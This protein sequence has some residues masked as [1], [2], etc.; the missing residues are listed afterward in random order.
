MSTPASNQQMEGL[1]DK[2]GSFTFQIR[3]LDLYQISINCEDYLSYS[4]WVYITKHGPPDCVKIP[5]FKEESV[6]KTDGAI[7]VLSADESENSGKVGL[8]IV[9]EGT[10]IL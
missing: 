3:N 2:I 6:M 7:I 5:M 8:R 1:T 9:P 4:K 10:N